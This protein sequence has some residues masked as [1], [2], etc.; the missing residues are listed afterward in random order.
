MSTPTEQQLRDLFAAD[1]AAAPQEDD[2]VDG[3]LRKVRHHRRVRRAGIAG[4]VAAVAAIGIGLANGVSGHEAQRP[5]VAAP[6]HSAGQVPLPTTGAATTPPGGGSSVSTSCI[7]GYSPA[8]LAGSSFAFDGTV[9]AIGPALSNRPGVALPLVGVTF[10][11]NQW[12]R[13]GS[14]PT[15]T[16]DMDPSP[17]ANSSS[18]S[19][20]PAYAVGTRLLVSGAPRWGG[21]P[22]DAAIAWGCGFTRSYDPQT[23]AEWAAATR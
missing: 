17:T 16:V 6:S 2:L 10:R 22:L 12:F 8:A 5:L 23:A 9:T 20:V 21:A 11:V 3:A 13:G 14:G 4:L 19:S 1:A 7:E 15:V 18:D